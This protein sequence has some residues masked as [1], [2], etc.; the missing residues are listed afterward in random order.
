MLTM[1]LNVPVLFVDHVLTFTML[2]T[3]SVPPVSMFYYCSLGN[4]H[5]E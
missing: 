2:S 1:R 4:Q 5:E 3:V